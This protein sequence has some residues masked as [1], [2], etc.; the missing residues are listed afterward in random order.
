MEAFCD[1]VAGDLDAVCVFGLE[2]AVLEG[3]G[4]EVDDGER[5]ALAGICICC[6]E[7]WL[8]LE[9]LDLEE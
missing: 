1:A 6:L 5:Q 8:A 3:G 4:E 7:R 2:S 9:M